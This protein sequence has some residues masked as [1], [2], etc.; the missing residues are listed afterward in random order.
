MELESDQSLI[1]RSVRLSRDA[2]KSDALQ[3]RFGVSSCSRRGACP[4][5]RFCRL[6]SWEGGVDE[7]S[8][9]Q[10]MALRDFRCAGVAALEQAAPGQE[11]RSR[12]TMNGTI[13]GTASEQRGIGPVHDGI[14]AELGDGGLENSKVRA[15]EKRMK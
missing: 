15:H 1:S 4:P 5:S 3:A 10:V 8:C 6:S 2:R 13:H 7:V 11:F 14:G 9:F 12:R